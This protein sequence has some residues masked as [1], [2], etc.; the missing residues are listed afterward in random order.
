LK[1]PSWSQLLTV[2]QAE[3]NATIVAQPKGLRTESQRLPV[4]YDTRPNATLIAEGVEADTLGLF[5]GESFPLSA[6]GG[7]DLP[8]QIILFLANIWDAG[9]GNE[10]NYREEV[11]ATY[12]HELGHYLGLDE[13]E[14]GARGLD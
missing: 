2:A 10:S 14:L 7:I 9:D 1:P 4:T 12:L 13:D 5:V 11:R 3:V 6:S 8:A